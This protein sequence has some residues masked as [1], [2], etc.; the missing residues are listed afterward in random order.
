MG[1]SEELE[2]RSL[3]WIREVAEVSGRNN[4]YLNLLTTHGIAI[5]KDRAMA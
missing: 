2:R 5:S 1:A 4:R 3:E